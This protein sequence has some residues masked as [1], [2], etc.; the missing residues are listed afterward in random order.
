MSYRP[1]DDWRPATRP[2]VLVVVWISLL[3]G[4]LG[5]FYLLGRLAW[6][7]AQLLA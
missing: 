1:P 5:T 3:A 4:C 2:W 6:W 7:L